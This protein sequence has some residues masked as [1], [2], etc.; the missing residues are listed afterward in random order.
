MSQTKLGSLIEASMSTASGFIVALV[1]WQLVGT[2]MG[3]K[4]TLHDN[5][6]I[7]SIFT[8]ASIARSY[9]W[10]RLFNRRK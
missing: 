3:Y 1:L 8:V 9:V 4:V 10:R 2:F 7:T 6:I 5:L